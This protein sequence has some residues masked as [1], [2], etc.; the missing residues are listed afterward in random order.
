ML[1]VTESTHR[2]PVG[3][4]AGSSKPASH[5][6]TRQTLRALIIEDNAGDALLVEDMLKRAARWSLSVQCV[7]TLH[8][9]EEILGNEG[10]VLDLVLLDMRLPDGDGL[11]ALARILAVRPEMAIVVLTGLDD[12]SLARACLEAGAVDYVRKSGLLGRNFIRTVDY[13]LARSRN[14]QLKTQLEGVGRLAALGEIAAGVAHEI[15]NPA[16]YVAYNIVDVQRSLSGLSGTL[17]A[18]DSRLAAKLGELAEMLEVA[19]EG[20]DRITAVVRGMQ[21]HLYQSTSEA[22]ETTEPVSVALSSLQLIDYQVRHSASVEVDFATCPAISIHP[23]RFGQ[24]VANLVL[25]A[26]QAV[27]ASSTHH[28][29]RVSLQVEGGA[30]LL[31]VRDDG[32]GIPAAELPRIFDSFYTSRRTLGGTG[33]GLSIVREIV[34]GAGGSIDVESEDGVGTVFSVRIPFA[35]DAAS[36]VATP[37]G[38]LLSGRRR[39]L[40]IDDDEPVLSALR[41]GLER[42]H[43]VWTAQSGGAALAILDTLEGEI[44]VILCDIAMPGM[45]GDETLR[46]VFERFPAL[47]TRAA[48]LSGGG[49]TAMLRSFVATTNMPVIAKP[50]SLGTLLN[51]IDA[52]ISSDTSRS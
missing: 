2:P 33:L 46:R 34:T 25:N 23:H 47:E 36:E 9:A 37:P 6:D 16:T 14:S 30:V 18:S 39:V 42:H 5:S 35:R 32:A 20:V 7:E 17:A 3:A 45:N 52:L 19:S 28:A 48:V 8:A 49:P 26:S 38:R 31:R 1:A 27:R 40:I 51:A 12:D 15:N 13:A 22:G 43:D 29:I 41:S 50:A 21:D 10:E 4:R 11:D 44:D 24:I